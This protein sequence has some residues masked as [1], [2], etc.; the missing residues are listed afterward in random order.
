M[1]VM[2]GVEKMTNRSRLGSGGLVPRHVI[3]ISISLSFSHP[4][5]AQAV[6][7]PGAA[8]NPAVPAS[9][10]P[11]DQ[12]ISI[13]ANT[14]V[15]LRLGDDLT[16]KGEQAKVGQ[17]FRLTVAYDV[18][19]NGIVAI[20]SGTPAIGEVTMRTGKGVFGKSGKLEVEMRRVDLN[21]QLIPVSGKYRQ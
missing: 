12:Q 1:T 19:V 8:A 11:F 9:A 13:P 14:E 2:Q 6:Q 16:S 18:R 10:Q 15:V 4:L 21:G 3:A 5:S 17:T 20:P 7:A